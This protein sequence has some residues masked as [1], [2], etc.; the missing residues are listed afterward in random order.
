MC[1][2]GR[3]RCVQCFV[4]SHCPGGEVCNGFTGECMVGCFRNSDCSRLQECDVLQARCVECVTSQH[5]YF[6][7]FGPEA[8]VCAY[9]ECRSCD[10]EHPCF[11][12]LTCVEGRCE[13]LGPPPQPSGPSGSQGPNDRPPPNPA[14]Y[15]PNPDTPPDETTDVIPHD[16]PDAGD[17]GTPFDGA[18][19]PDQR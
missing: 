16:G 15:G 4:N 6:D 9:N 10:A 12:S 1:D 5:C 19:A 2:P 11:G 14:P 8:S 3:G 13:Q 7:L 17:G 18:D